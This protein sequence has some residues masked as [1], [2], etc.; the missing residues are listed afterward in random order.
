MA[1]RTEE[2]AAALDKLRMDWGLLNKAVGTGTRL[3]HNELVVRIVEA[4]A[5]FGLRSGAL[6]TMVLISANPGCSQS[7][8][9]REVAMDDSAMVAIIDQLE[10]RGLAVRSRSTAD[11]RRNT[12]SL[13]P[14][15]EALMHEMTGRAMDVESPIHDA[16]SPDEQVMLV[17]LLR[18]A[19][20]AIIATPRN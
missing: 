1:G 7:E 4:Y 3:L 19:Y 10:R 5:P 9:A 16:L 20:S 15:G 8:L 17:T 12:L 2:Q 14:E 13:T 11:R 18:R 6:S